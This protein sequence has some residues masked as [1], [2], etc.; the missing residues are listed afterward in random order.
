[1]RSYL[2]REAVT[3][4]GA[5]VMGVALVVRLARVGVRVPSL[6]YYGSRSS[7]EPMSI[8][9]DGLMDLELPRE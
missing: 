4:S 9:T 8:Q 1:M 3:P 2:D 6:T 5:T 7:P